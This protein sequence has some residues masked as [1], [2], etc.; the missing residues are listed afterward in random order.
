MGRRLLGEP[1]F[2][3][4]LSNELGAPFKPAFGLEWDTTALDTL[5]LQNGFGQVAW[6]VHINPVLDRQLVGKQLQRNHLQH[7]R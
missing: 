4:T 5:L 7:G 2:T 1:R 3:S 6:M